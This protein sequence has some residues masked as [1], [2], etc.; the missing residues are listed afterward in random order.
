MSA[1][2]V[3]TISAYQNLKVEREG[4][5]ARVILN[6]PSRRNALSLDLMRE[7]IE[8]LSA[9]ARD[10]EI[11]AI[12]LGAEGSVFCAGHDLA[13]MI[14]KNINEYRHIFDTCTEL[15]V[16]IQS[17]PQPVIA[18]VQGTATAAGCQLVATCDLAIASEKAMFGT[19]GVKLGLFCTTPMVALSRAVGRKRALQ[20]LLSGE[21]INASTAADWG[22]VNAVVPGEA[23]AQETGKLAKK[24]AAASP[25]TIGLG[26]QAFYAQVDLDQPKAYAY[27]KEVMSMNSLALDA[28]EGMSAFLEKRPACWVGR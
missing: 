11:H 3:E 2:S 25:L 24:V 16:K 17:I 28:Q 5:V 18:E 23:L 13:E 19:P 4:A 20:M 26:K 14:G 27:A 21:M 8:Y 9:T 7:L 1:G 12:I 15:M 6:R 10:Q 22:L